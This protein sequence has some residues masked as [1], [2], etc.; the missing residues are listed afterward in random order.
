MSKEICGEC[1]YHKF[2]RGEHNEW[3]CTNCNS[4]YYTDY[5]DYTDTCPMFQERGIEK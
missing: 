3:H 4:D 5:T 2:I 1:K